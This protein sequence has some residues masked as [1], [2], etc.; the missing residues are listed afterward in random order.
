M[1]SF[2]Q[3][4]AED[5]EADRCVADC[6]SREPGSYVEVSSILAAAGEKQGKKSGNG[7]L[8]GMKFLTN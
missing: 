5:A 1:V 6:A 3:G 4:S 8:D 7:W 2:G